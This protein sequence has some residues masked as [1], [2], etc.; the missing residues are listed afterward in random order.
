MACVASQNLFPWTMEHFG[1]TPRGWRRRVSAI[2]APLGCDRKIR[3]YIIFRPPLPT[4]DII[5]V[6][7]SARRRKNNIRVAATK[8]DNTLLVLNVCVLY[9]SYIQK[10]DQYM[11]IYTLCIS[12][13]HIWYIHVCIYCCLLY[14]NA[15]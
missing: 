5:P 4:L 12:T 13:L 11:Y 3:F 1:R 10:C 14:V 9:E 15:L 2:I 6:V 7:G 8:K